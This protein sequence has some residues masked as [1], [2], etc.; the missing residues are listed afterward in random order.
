MLLANDSS[1][2]NIQKYFLEKNSFHAHDSG[3]SGE[4]MPT[5]LDYQGIEW[6]I[7]M[8]HTSRQALRENRNR[9]YVPFRQFAHEEI[10]SYPLKKVEEHEP[11]YMF[12]KFYKIPNL[13]CGHFQLKRNLMAPTKTDLIYPSSVGFMHHSLLEF[14]EKKFNIKD[15]F[16]PVGIDYYKGLVAL[17]ALDG[18]LAIYNLQK[19]KVVSNTKI[20]KDGSI[21]NCVNFFKQKETNHPR[22]CCGG[23]DNSIQIFDIGPAETKL[24]K[25]YMMETPVNDLKVSADGNLLLILED[26]KEC[27]I[28]DIRSGETMAVLRG[29]ED[30]GFSGDWHPSGFT[31][32]TGNQDSTCRIWDLRKSEEA[33]NILQAHIGTVCSLSYSRSGSYLVVAENVDFVNIYDTTNNYESMQVIDFFGEVTGMSF[34]GEDG[35]SLFFGVMLDGRNGVFEY[36]KK[37]SKS[38]FTLSQFMF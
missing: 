12:E 26:Q 32:A 9:K 4:N 5:G 31:V 27:I 16:H 3:Y 36:N 23:N 17:S 15:D 18:N 14:K 6:K 30:F 10:S 38:L 13:W 28:K 37:M 2:Q 25:K 22:I 19:D 34:D 33:V 35:D 20:I 21:N 24:I 29:H 8:S 1:E 7:E 11:Y